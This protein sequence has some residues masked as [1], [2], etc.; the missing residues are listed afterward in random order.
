VKREL[1]EK[2]NTANSLLIFAVFAKFAPFAV[3]N[4]EEERTLAMIQILTVLTGT[5]I[6]VLTLFSAISTFVLP[7]SA[8]SQLNRLVFGV[9]RRLIEFLFRFFPSYRAR[10]AIM[11][12]YAPIGLLLLVPTW[13]L[14]V[15]IGYSLIYWGIGVGDF[16]SSMRLSG[17]SLLTLG[18]SI[19]DR[20]STSLLAF[21]EAAIGL[22][23]VG[24]LIA[25]LP[26]MYAAFSRREQAVNLLTVRAGSPPAALEM[27][28]RYNRVHGLV[29]LAA[30]WQVWESWFADLEESHTTLP[31]LVFFRSPD[32][33]NSW[34]TAAGAVL[35]TASLT[36]S[37][38]DIPYDPSGALCIRAGFIALRRIAEYFDIN[39]PA[40]P[41]FPEDPIS[42]YREEFDIVLESL[43][44]QGVPL[45]ADREQAW[46]DFAGWR[47]NYDR[48]LLSLCSLVMAPAA[49][50]SSD[51]AAPFKQLPIFLP[52][53]KGFAKSLDESLRTDS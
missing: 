51:R 41:H 53:K 1:R 5:S 32:P 18:F 42:V 25:Y 46:R 4:P 3:R 24:L 21:S 16:F 48:V 33:E 43:A 37:S 39:Y 14:L 34:V 49:P 31:A 22:I 2:A 26:T 52:R 28:Q 17:S 15:I 13:Y 35:D 38:L 11:A 7:R 29:K 9:L 19:P 40:D 36:L 27:L 23:L 45:K 30:Y 20:V 6:V 44:A 10:D 47:V 8:R 12:Y 50:W